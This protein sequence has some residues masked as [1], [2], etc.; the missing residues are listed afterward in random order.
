MTRG[1]KVD[2]INSIIPYRNNVPF[3]TNQYR[4]YFYSTGRATS[5]E[6]VIHG[7]SDTDFFCGCS[8]IFSNAPIV[9]NRKDKS[10]KDFLFRDSLPP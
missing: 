2:D 6:G 4:H 8:F 1:V 5:S 10:P 3:K 7:G 9:A